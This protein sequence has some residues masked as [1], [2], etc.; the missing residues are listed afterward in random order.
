MSPAMISGGG[1]S[2][3]HENLQPYLVLNWCI[4]LQGIY[5]SRN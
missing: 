4:A 2:L 5:P 3:P 1:S